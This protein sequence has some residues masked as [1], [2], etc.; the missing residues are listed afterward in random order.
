L[1]K[2]CWSRCI[3]HICVFTNVWYQCLIAEKVQAVCVT[4]V[5]VHT[6]DNTNEATF[7]L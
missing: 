4:D 1:A 6:V 2:K 7:Y 3:I 5:C